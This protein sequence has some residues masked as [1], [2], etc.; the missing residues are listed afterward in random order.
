VPQGRSTRNA[1]HEDDYCGY[2]DADGGDSDLDYEDEPC[3]AADAPSA[4]NRRVDPSN[5]VAYTR[6]E[7]IAEY[8]GTAEWDAAAPRTGNG[9]GGGAGGHRAGNGGGSGREGGGKGG[10]GKGGGGKGGGGKG[11][12]GKGGG[13][14][15]GD[16]KVAAAA[17]QLAP[18]RPASSSTPPMPTPEAAA[19][20]VAAA[21]GAAAAAAAGADADVA[22]PRSSQLN[23]VVAGHVDAGKSTLMGRLLAACGRVDARTLHKYEREAAQAGKASFKWAWVLD[24]DS[25]ERARG[26]TIEVGVAHFESAR[27]K[28]NVLDTPGHRD[29]VPNMIGGAAQADAALL[30]LNAAASEFEAGLCGQTAEHLLLLRALGVRQLVVVVNKMDAANWEQQRYEEIVAGVA[31]LLAQAGW[32]MPLPP[33]VPIS[34]LAAQN[35]TPD[36]PAAGGGGW[37]PGRTLLEEIDALEPA[38]R[39]ESKGGAQLCVNDVYRSLMLGPATVSG[40]LQAGTL[41]VGQPLMLLPGGGTHTVKA[42]ASRGEAAA[43]VTA[44]DHVELSLA[45]PPDEGAIGAGS[46]LCDPSRPVPLAT[47]VEVQLRVFSPPAPLTKGQPFEVYVHTASAPAILHKI[48]AG[49]QKDGVRAAARPRFLVAQSAAVVQLRFESPICLQPHA[50]C[51]GLGRLVLREAGR[52]LAAG[53]VTAILDAK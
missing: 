5:G 28:V 6:A 41:S 9:G 33:V 45:P 1:I 40:T 11:G 29:F 26:V 48:V 23:L 42:L 15:G 51:R 14:T 37:Y 13:G 22:V 31:P 18:S 39:R 2:D 4:A 47:I 52:T 34:A 46:L 12:G 8:G 36:A 3:L 20:A 43:A 35:L 25:E 32:R 38:D 17:P 7:F 16:A 44:G 21:A 10:G 53:I 49:V 19:A 50:V 30:L 24:Q 27:L